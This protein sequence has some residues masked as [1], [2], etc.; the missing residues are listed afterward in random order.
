VKEAFAHAHKAVAQLTNATLMQETADPFDP[1]SKRTRVDSAGI[2]TWHTFDHYGQMV[3]YAR[4]NG[5]V[6]PASQ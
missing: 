6:P 1:K 5:I 3:E 4:M 2:L